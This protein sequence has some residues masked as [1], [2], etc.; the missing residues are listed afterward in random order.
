MKKIEEGGRT[1]RKRTFELAYAYMIITPCK[2]CGSPVNKGYICMFCNDN[3]PS[4]ER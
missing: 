1:Y 4:E 2:K 3:N